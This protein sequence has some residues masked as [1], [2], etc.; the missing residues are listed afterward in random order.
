MLPEFGLSHVLLGQRLSNQP[1]V[2]EK[3]FV[4]WY[5]LPCCLGG[6]GF[7]N[8]T[9]CEV[10]WENESMGLAFLRGALKLG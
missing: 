9:D 6:C 5:V 4:C 7:G 3:G 1:P 10:S 2:A 8:H